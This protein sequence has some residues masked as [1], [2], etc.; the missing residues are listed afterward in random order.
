MW[1]VVQFKL[2]TPA[3]DNPTGGG[4]LRDEPATTSGSAHPSPT[5]PSGCRTG[6][7]ARLEGILTDVSYGNHAGSFEVKPQSG[8]PV[9]FDVG[10][11]QEGEVPLLDRKVAVGTAIADRPPHRSVRAEL[12]HTAPA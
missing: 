6:F 1:S 8:S 10:D 9:S 12:P 3:P 11:N 2:G 7:P 5:R 4:Y